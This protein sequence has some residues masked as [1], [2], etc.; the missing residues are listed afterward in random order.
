[1]RKGHSFQLTNTPVPLQPLQMSD[2]TAF[3]ESS[4]RYETLLGVEDPSKYKPGGYHPL[5]I[6]E[7]VH[8]S[9]YLILHRLGHG[10]YSTVWLALDQSYDSSASSDPLRP[11][12]VALKIG[13]ASRGQKEA[14]FLNELQA[15]LRSR[16]AQDECRHVVRFL[17]YFQISGPNGSHCCLVTE[18]LGPSVAD[19]HRYPGIG[20]RYWLPLP[21][22]RHVALLCAEALAVLHSQGI[23]HAGILQHQAGYFGSNC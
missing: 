13:I 18:L 3:F 4:D 8:D 5:E 22:A 10:G 15:Q 19:L 2:C 7:K 12:Y 23:V 21:V 17:D 11:R 16:P 14:N 20:G 9:R 1:M 6:G